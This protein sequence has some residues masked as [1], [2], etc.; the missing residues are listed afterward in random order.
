MPGLRRDMLASNP[1]NSACSHALSIRCV[2]N[3][4]GKV[5]MKGNGSSTSSLFHGMPWLSGAPTF[6]ATCVTLQDLYENNQISGEVLIKMDIEG[7][8]TL[9]VPS[10]L[11]W[12]FQHTCAHSRIPAPVQA[13][14]AIASTH[15]HTNTHTHSQNKRR[16]SRLE[17]KPSFFISFHGQATLEQKEEIA[18]VFNLYKHYAV[19]KVMPACCPF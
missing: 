7:A 8:E 9:V 5:K 14:A 10:L 19:L 13:H 18:K 16:L 6:D 11:D 4:R 1:L 17:T 3:Q 2:S 12:Y 15:T